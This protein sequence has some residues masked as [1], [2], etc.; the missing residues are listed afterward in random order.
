M[1]ILV[2]KVVAYTIFGFIIL[3]TWKATSDSGVNTVQ[4]QMNYILID[5]RHRNTLKL[6][7]TSECR[8]KYRPHTIDCRDEN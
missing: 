7:K 1:M 4:N 3:C 5:C 6:V 2:I 8:G